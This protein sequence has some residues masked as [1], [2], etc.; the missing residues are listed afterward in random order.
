MAHRHRRRPAGV[1]RGG[2]GCWC[3]VGRGRGVLVGSIRFGRPQETR[4]G[5]F[6]NPVV[7]YAL[8][9]TTTDLGARWST[10]AR[11]DSPLAYGK[12]VVG[13]WPWYVG[14]YLAVQFGAANPS[15]ARTIT[16]WVFEAPWLAFLAFAFYLLAKQSAA[17]KRAL[18]QAQETE[19]HE[20][21]TKVRCWVCQHVQTVPVGQEAF[22]C[23]QCKA[24]L[25]RPTASANGS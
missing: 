15:L 19:V 3:G 12:G 24:H 10:F 17:R 8:S 6:K 14:T 16:G 20:K 25:K 2:G 11:K 7:P 18:A 13:V 23:E 22:S 9:A 5:S 21:C 4:Q 1:F